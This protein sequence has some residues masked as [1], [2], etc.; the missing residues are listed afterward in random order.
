MPLIMA[1][2]GSTQ[3]GQVLAVGEPERQGVS[4]L[5]G[6]WYMKG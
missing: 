3:F 1:Q 6:V 4:A 2:E 5:A